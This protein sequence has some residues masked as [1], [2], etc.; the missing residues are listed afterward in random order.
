MFHRNK[1]LT[2]CRG[3][4]GY[5]ALAEDDRGQNFN[6]AGQSRLDRSEVNFAF[7]RK[8]IIEWT[9]LDKDRTNKKISQWPAHRKV[10]ATV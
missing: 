8:G 7:S 1:C 10:S 6:T 9:T 5:T 4:G 3:R 2:V